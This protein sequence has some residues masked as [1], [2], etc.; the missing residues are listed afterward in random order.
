[1]C[2]CVCVRERS[3]RSV[4]SLFRSLFCFIFV[5]LVFLLLFFSSSGGKTKTYLVYSSSA[6]SFPPSLPPSLP[7]FLPLLRTYLCIKMQHYWHT[8]TRQRKS[9][10]PVG[11]PPPLISLFVSLHS[12]PHPSLPPSLPRSLPPPLRIRRRRRGQPQTTPLRPLHMNE[13]L[14]KRLN[15]WIRPQYLLRHITTLIHGLHLFPPPHISYLPITPLN[16]NLRILSLP[17]QSEQL[18]PLL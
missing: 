15:L 3:C 4:L 17:P 1:V 16:I 8:H 6:R 9:Y 14:I 7:P 18:I 11:F 5:S 13:N 10:S 2:V 12:L